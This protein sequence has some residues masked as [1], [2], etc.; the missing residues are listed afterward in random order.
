M[1]FSIKPAGAPMAPVVAPPVNN[2]PQAASANLSDQVVIDQA[3]ASIVYQTVDSLT[4]TV[5][6]QFPDEAVLRRRAYFHALDRTKGAPTRPLATDR[7][8]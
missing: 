6:W 5:V 3:T 1:N 7:T 2:G 4:D 8:A